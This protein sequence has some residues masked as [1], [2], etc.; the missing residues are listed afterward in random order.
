V[1]LRET[2]NRAATVVAALLLTALAAVWLARS[3]SDG[4]EV[5]AVFD[6]VNGLVEGADVTAAG[7][8]VGSVERIAL[9][10]DGLPLVTLRIDGNYRLERGAT[11]EI[12]EGSAA[13]QVNRTVQV[14]R[15]DGP[16]LAD[17]ATLGL[18]RTDQPVE[19]DQVL[20]MLDRPTRT[21]VE[22][23][24]ASLAKATGGEG[25]DLRASLARST[26]AIGNTANLAAEIGADGE[27]LR[28]AIDRGGELV[29]ALAGSRDRL[30]A[31]AERLR[32]ALG[33]A[34]ARQTELRRIAER[35]P[36]GLT[37]PRQALERLDATVPVLRALVAGA[38]PGVEKLV[39][40]SRALRPALA[41]AAPALDQAS[42]L[43]GDAPHQLAR[44]DP[45]LA[46]AQP[47]LRTLD[48]VLRSSGPILDEARVRMPDFFSFFSNW[49]D[50]TSVYDANGHAARVGLVL[51]PAPENS[52]DGSDP[53]AGNL[54]APFVRTPGVLEGE[55]WQDYQDSFLFGAGE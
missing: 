13:G 23:A 33:V 45:L 40:F 54:I 10:D 38:G 36:A 53:G 49:A 41:E 20:S 46:A 30:T 15:G 31:T 48:P 44:L 43:V 42:A 55:P 16:E 34:A 3:G 47:T 35:L 50:F 22:S 2:S 24:L 17:G 14:E 9:G 1:A 39:G 32:S 12:R 6:Q 8:V 11:A 18:A 19:A 7:T 51:P 37:A 4:Y 21:Q 27:A 28:T 25:Q 26:A 52:I 5:T 29:A